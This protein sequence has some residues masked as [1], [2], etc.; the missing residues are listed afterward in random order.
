[1]VV[2][3]FASSSWTVL[4]LVKLVSAFKTYYSKTKH[5]KTKMLITQGYNEN[6]VLHHKGKGVMYH[7]A[8]HLHIR[9]QVMLQ[10]LF[11]TLSH[12]MNHHPV[13]RRD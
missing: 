2:M 6:Y 10:T 4:P 5:K 13:E 3:A 1:M 12:D 9:T 11:M 7:E 8:A